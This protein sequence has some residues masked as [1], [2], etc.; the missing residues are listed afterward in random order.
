MLCCYSQT[1]YGD[2]PTNGE[3]SSL[4]A[5]T[6]SPSHVELPKNT[7]TDTTLTLPDNII[8]SSGGH[9]EAIVYCN[10]TKLPPDWKWIE[11]NKICGKMGKFNDTVKL[12]K[13]IHIEGD[14]LK[15]FINKKV[16]D[17]PVLKERFDSLDDLNLKFQKFDEIKACPGL[18]DQQFLKIDNSKT[19]VR[20]EKCW[21]SKT[22]LLVL[23]TSA[24]RCAQCKKLSQA[25]K[26]KLSRM[27]RLVAKTRK[28]YSNLQAISRK[29]DRR[30]I[31]LEETKFKS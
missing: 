10:Q 1:D 12:S 25:M 9:C 24:F 16:I 28:K 15:Y 8:L 30:T 6:N 31:A 19:G 29:L 4:L 26:K 20:K 27:D 21:R 13:A 7:S 2:H 18:L 17:N 3:P 11:E 5:I 14:S 23:S 22:C